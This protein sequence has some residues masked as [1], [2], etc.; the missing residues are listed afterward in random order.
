MNFIAK[1]NYLLRIQ[2]ISFT[3][4]LQ[5]TKLKRKCIQNI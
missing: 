4:K 5:Y 1:Y 2:G 3:V